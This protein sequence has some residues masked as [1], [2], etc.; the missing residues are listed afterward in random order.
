MRKGKGRRPLARWR[1]HPG[2]EM[3]VEKW[4]G[5]ASPGS[6]PL[7][8]HG[9]DSPALDTAQ[10]H[11]SEPL[12]TGCGA[13][14][15]GCSRMAEHQ[16]P[17]PML[18]GRYRAAHGWRQRRTIPIAQGGWW[19]GVERDGS[20]ILLVRDVGRQLPFF[21]AWMVG[22]AGWPWVGGVDPDARAGLGNRR[23]GS[24]AG[25]GW[26]WK[27]SVVTSV[28]GARRYG[29]GMA[30][31]TTFCRSW[32]P[33]H[34]GGRRGQR[35]FARRVFRRVLRVVVTSS[36]TEELL[37][38]GQS[39]L[40]R[41]KLCRTAGSSSASAN[42]G[43][44]DS[45]HRHSLVRT[46]LGQMSA[47]ARRRQFWHGTGSASAGALR[48]IRDWDSGV[49]P[50]LS[51]TLELQAATLCRGFQ[52]PPYLRTGSPSDPHSLTLAIEMRSLLSPLRRASWRLLPH[53][54]LSVSAIGGHEE[55]PGALV[56]C[57]DVKQEDKKRGI[58]RYPWSGSR[59]ARRVS[60][61][62]SATAEKT[63]LQHSYRVQLRPR[64]SSVICAARS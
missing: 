61:K 47:Q 8:E 12:A 21:R 43:E 39:F 57:N 23:G 3:A 48:G 6:R 38:R 7:A 15:F 60:C 27:S 26:R 10:T 50:T 14:P 2:Q 64:F 55:L 25:G 51:I 11:I 58:E 49:G 18:L 53:V 56:Q 33:W 19:V 54:G 31:R 46:P 35:R 1:G 9:S 17:K 13:E 16:G 40:Q 45:T 32:D 59:S 5:F 29:T 42:S 30:F 28:I 22:G 34:A 62:K 37:N 20:G 4:Q 24:S 41:L 36:G 63:P 44:I 52:P